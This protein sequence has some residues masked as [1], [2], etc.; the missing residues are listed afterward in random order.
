VTA[1]TITRRQGEIFHDTLVVGG[2][3][4]R[5]QIVSALGEEGL[6]VCEVETLDAIAQAP[7]DRS[8]SL[9]IFAI[10]ESGPA[11]SSAL[12]SLGKDSPD[13]R[14]VLVCASIRGWEVR[15]ALA[16]GASGI[17]LSD[18]LPTTLWACLL[19]VQAG[20]TCVPH[21]NGRQIERAVLSTRERQ[22]LGLVVMGFMNCQIAERLFL[23][24]STIKSHLSSAFSKL[25]VH[26][27]NEAI[28]LILNSPGGLSMGILSLGGNPVEHSPGGAR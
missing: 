1:A 25:E 11:L 24:E 4:V 26:S 13:A 10:D 22:I 20:L 16:A 21:R 2:A 18:E 27:R 14:V 5:L 9:V 3:E 28:D 7:L 12:E 15:A 17:V 23:A 19:A 6:E 8:P